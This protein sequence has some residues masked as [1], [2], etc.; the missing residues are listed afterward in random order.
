MPPSAQMSMERRLVAAGGAQSEGRSVIYAGERGTCNGRVPADT[1]G[2]DA[3]QR[4]WEY[5]EETNCVNIKYSLRRHVHFWEKVLKPSSFVLNVVKH[6]YILPLVAEPPM[7]YAKNN[8]SSLRYRK[9]VEGAIG[10]LEKGGLIKEV[11]AQPY[12]CNPLSVADKGKLRLVLDLRHVNL[13]IADKTFRYEDLTTLAEILNKDDFFVNFDLRSGYHHIDIHP[14]H[15]KYLGFQWELEIG[16]AEVTRFFVFTVMPFGLKP[17]SYVFT[18]VLR[19]FTKYWRGMG[20]K[21]VIYIDDGISA[22]K[23]EKL[24]K[25]AGD[26][27]TANLT[28]AGFYINWG[29]SNMEPKQV[30]RWLGTVVDTRKMRFSVPA[31]KINKVRADIDYILEKDTCTAKQLA[32]IA[33]TLSSMHLAIGKII[34]LFTRKIYAQI[35]TRQPW[36]NYEPPEEGTSSELRVWSKNIGKFNG[37]S[38]KPRV[39][40]SKMVFTDASSTGYGGFYVSKLG[41]HIC[42]GEFTNSE[43]NSSST[44]R[45]LLAVKLVLQSYGEELSGQSIQI[46]VDNQAATRILSVGSSKEHLQEVALDIFHYCLKNDIRLTPEW[47]PRE[48]N[49]DADYLSRIQDSDSWGVDMQSFDYI[50]E[51]FG[52]FDIDR[53]ADNKNTKLVNFNSKYYC[54]GS[55][56]VNTFTANWHGKNNWLCP[57]VKNIPAVI[58]HLQCCKAMGTLLIPCWTSAFWWPL[59]YPDGKQLATFIKGIL[60]MDPFYESYSDSNTVFKG[61]QAFKT[62]ALKIDFTT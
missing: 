43:A 36:W 30:G 53:F 31:E 50:Q 1:T 38:F 26:V 11:D 19:P 9:F 40:N 16:G 4:D 8:R 39:T 12:C 5:S 42:T 34:R 46:N 20:I 25:E 51:K 23:T 14:D 33:D 18:K 55:M 60:I 48:F 54:P 13:Y 2:D 58:R 15:Q 24:A 56:H 61:F 57:P 44:F 59:I 22:R 3:Y 45:E 27:I 41:Q 47:V 29:K 32:K 49:R 10:D 37:C 17:A 21:V 6:G 28:E 7:F 35:E 52:P 62:L